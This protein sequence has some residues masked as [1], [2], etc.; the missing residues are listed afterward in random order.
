[1]FLPLPF[2]SKELPSGK[3]LYRRKHGY[4]LTLNANGDTVYTITVPYL[5][6]KI[7][8]AEIIHCPEGVTL[9][10]KVK[11]STTGT[12]TGTPNYLLNQFGF[13]INVGKDLFSDKSDYDADVFTGMQLEFTFHNS[14]ATS[15]EIGINIVFHEIK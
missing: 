3:K 9:D 6:A 5:E 1:M 11:D 2:A 7:N 8:E 13:N 4:S 10:M 15:K 14:T 12:Y